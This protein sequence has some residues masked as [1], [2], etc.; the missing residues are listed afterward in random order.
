MPD[1]SLCRLCERELADAYPLVRFATRVTAE[2]W[3]SFAR[4]LIA[5]GGGAIAARADDGCLHGIAIF[6]PLDS[7]RHVRCLYVELLVVFELTR[8]SPVHDLLCAA[9]DRVARELDCPSILLTLPAGRRAGRAPWRGPGLSL[10]AMGFVRQTQP[11][12]G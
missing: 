3:T 6:R 10:E 11:E 9:L 12:R 5:A 8:R 4:A 1:L 2:R 7:L